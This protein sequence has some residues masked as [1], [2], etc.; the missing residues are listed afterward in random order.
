M[1]KIFSIFLTAFMLFALTVA[2]NADE[3]SYLS[4]KENWEVSASSEMSNSIKKAFDNDTVTHWHTKYNP[5]NTSEKDAPP[6]YFYVTLPQ[7]E[8]ISGFV[9]TPRQGTT[10]KSGWFLDYEIYASE[11]DSENYVLLNKGTF[12]ATNAVKP[13]NFGLNTKIKKI[14]FVVLSG[15]NGYATMGEFDLVKAVESYDTV[16]LSEY[17]NYLE[18][19]ALYKIDRTNFAASAESCWEKN[20]A[21]RLIDGNTA[22]FWHEKP[23]DVGPF[24][25]I[26]DMS[27][28]YTVQGFDYT[29]RQQDIKGH[30]EIFSVYISSDGENYDDVLLDESMKPI[31]FSVK[32]IKF[33]N[34]V[35][36]RY[37][38]FVI[39]KYQSHCAV[40]E[41]EPFQTKEAMEK[42]NAKTREKYLLKI[43]SND[44][45]ISKDD[46]T[47][48][49]TIDTAPFIKNGNTLIPLRGLMEE[50]GAEIEWNGDNKTVTVTGEMTKIELQI[51]N[52]QVYVTTPRYGRIR[53]ALRTAPVIRDGRTFIPLRFISEHL[54]YN[55]S[56]DGEKQEITIENETE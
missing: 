17:K 6:F 1:K 40:S 46:E 42:D 14:K 32:R 39:S 29:P 19:N 47:Y 16:S 41:I 55:V 36:G 44:I 56:W 28:E 15:L 20:T 35:R 4:G 23:G 25:V 50:M 22:T 9:Y 52:K 26:I 34:E 49:K 12:A 2:V 54:G 30:W 13:V 45:S 51:Y 48:T 18:S 33:K 21:D 31:D 11:D 38:K 27:K 7:A 10:S 5:E 8:E 24:T 53:Y 3:S 37:I 43:N